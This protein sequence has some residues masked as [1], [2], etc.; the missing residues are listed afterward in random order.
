M[1]E[2]AKKLARLK[3]FP[4][5]KYFLRGVIALA[6]IAV[7]SFALVVMSTRG[8]PIPQKQ[9]REQ[10]STAQKIVNDVTELNPVRVADII[11]PHTIEEIVGA[12]KNNDHV[13][14][15]GGRNSMGG[16]TASER[17]V[18]IDM[19]EYNKILE[20][21]PAKKEITLEAGIRWRDIL[22]Y[23]DPHNLSVK[24]MQTYSNFT[25]GGSLS[26]NV[27]G[28]Y[29]GLG[30]I[31]LS[32][33][34]FR[35]VL[36]DGSIVEASPEK[37]PDIFYSAIGGMGGIGVISDVTLE[38]ADNVNVERSR[39]K[40]PT[41]QYWEYF[42][43]SVRSDP[44]VIFHNGDMYPPD[45]EY[46]S[47]VSWTETDKA[48]TTKERLIPRTQDYWKERIAWVVMSEWP[49]GRWVRE[50]LAGLYYSGEQPVHTR[51][52][53]AS[54][55]IAELEPKDRE[56]STYVLQEYFVPVER[57]DEW[58][59]KMK[60][61]FDDHDVNVINVSIR[62]A[63]PDPGAKLAWAR[64]ESF[65]FVVYFKQGT[66]DESKDEVGKWTREMIDQVLLVG[67][68]YYLPYQ[69]LATDDQFHR[70]Y[71]GALDFFEIKKTYDPTDKFT[72]KLW[73]KYYNEEKFDHYK[74]KQRV[75]TV[76]STTKE[77]YRPF[78]NAYLA[79]PE[80]YIVYSADEYAA[81]LRDALPSDFHYFTA[82]S[83]YW[84]QYD[85]VMRLT[86]SS[87]YDNS[88]YVAVL[89]VIGW[90]FTAENVMK[91]I[92]ENTIGC[93]SE[94]IAGDTQVAEDLY[95]AKVAK[96]YADFIYDYPWYDFPYFSHFT[97]V[98]TLDN[99]REHT[100]RQA[101]RRFERKLFLSLEYGVKSLYSS[102]IA[103]ATH[104]KFGVQDDVVYAVVTRDGGKTHELIKAP[105]YQPF[106]RLLVQ[107]MEHESDNEHFRII[108]ISGN[109]KI[110]LTYRDEVGTLAVHGARE[111]ARDTE[112]NAM[113]G[114]RAEYLDR[115]T[116][117]MNVQDIPIAYSA[118]K[119]RAIAID[120]FYDY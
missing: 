54:Y 39:M 75:L 46:V 13:S 67:G 18:Q 120:H 23:I 116:V 55:D 24:I 118:L 8:N 84:D 85:A 31:I 73:D 77:Y 28:R 53:E 88:D 9:E 41:S 96:E 100:W 44:K 97:G 111:I 5:R 57:F 26:V 115:I 19:R 20:F 65:A 27:H 119:E 113:R 35:I 59:P 117:E 106:T 42:N 58:I 92:Y 56:K 49:E 68:T 93:L 74:K 86:A 47:A 81:V 2:I 89:R 82:T 69:L 99:E 91:G 51:N 70:A 48:P 30:P 3:D 63:L 6:A 38:L 50:L 16:Q 60:K 107:E 105:H 101:I 21:S 94:W 61:V 37:H 110:T 78:D 104:T 98:W 102:V 45:F 33:K 76:A 14:I 7:F 25:V 87:T 22:E 34:N 62:H 43:A 52:Y 15:G 1:K 72:N 64:T 10:A 17:A 12:V 95:A 112:I 90:S 40:M 109:D 11:V 71:P 83:D 114:G 29:I 79:L 80:W 36:A 108:N 4:M 32:V 66:D 103:F